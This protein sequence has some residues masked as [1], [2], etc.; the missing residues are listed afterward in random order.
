M[1][2][3]AFLRVV[4]NVFHGSFLS[5][6]VDRSADF[7]WRCIASS[8][9]CSKDNAAS[10]HGQTLRWRK[11]LSADLHARPEWLAVNGDISLRQRVRVECIK[12]NFN[13]RGSTNG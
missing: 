4:T 2:G 13:A 11:L 1:L 5:F 7:G 9:S 8:N 10:T 6:L 3:I 12:G